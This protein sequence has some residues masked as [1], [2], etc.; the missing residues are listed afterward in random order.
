MLIT[1][2]IGYIFSESGLNRDCVQ[3]ECF[4]LFQQAGYG[5]LQLKRQEEIYMDLN[6]PKVSSELR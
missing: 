4:S 3:Q 1:P 2:S 5:K 6:K